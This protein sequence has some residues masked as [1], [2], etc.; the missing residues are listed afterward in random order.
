M[1]GPR[2]GPV[3]YWVTGREL[4]DKP[5]GVGVEEADRFG[6]AVSAALRSETARLIQQLIGKIEGREITVAE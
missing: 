5:G 6:A 1:I 4:R 3:T 2:P